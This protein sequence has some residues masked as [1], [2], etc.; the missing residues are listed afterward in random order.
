MIT[1]L[2]LLHEIKH[3]DEPFTYKVFEN[4]FYMQ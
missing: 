2:I 1:Q 3:A 4:S